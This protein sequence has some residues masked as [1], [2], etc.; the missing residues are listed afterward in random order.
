M[1]DFT[2]K[3]IIDADTIEVYPGWVYILPGS[4]TQVKDNKIRI[5][6]F[7]TSPNDNIV[8]NRLTSLLLN[9]EVDLVN[10][11]VVGNVGDMPIIGCNVYIG[12]TD[13]SYYFPE[14][15]PHL[16]TEYSY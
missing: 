3:G 9:K 10:P 5:L 13:I 12:Q 2:V 4:N 6:G 14:Y 15:T 8:K 16:A 7:K 1:E 11:R